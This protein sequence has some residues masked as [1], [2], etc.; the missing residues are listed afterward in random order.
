M[1]SKTEIKAAP[2]EVTSHKIPGLS[3]VELPENVLELIVNYVSESRSDLFSFL[4]TCK[5]LRVITENASLQLSVK[6]K[7]AQKDEPETGVELINFMRLSTQWKIWRLTID[8]DHALFDSEK[9][10]SAISVESEFLKKFSRL[11]IFSGIQHRENMNRVRMS[12]LNEIIKIMC[13]PSTKISFENLDFEYFPLTGLETLEQVKRVNY[14]GL[15]NQ[16]G[17]IAYNICPYLEGLSIRI[18][19]FAVSPFGCR[20]PRMVRLT[21]Q[22]FLEELNFIGSWDIYSCSF[23]AQKEII[24]EVLLPELKIFRI[25][26]SRLDEI[27]W[28]VFL[29]RHALK[30]RFLVINGCSRIPEERIHWEIL[31]ESCR[32]LQ[33]SYEILDG[34]CLS[35]FLSE[36]FLSDIPTFAKSWTDFDY[37]IERIDYIIKLLAKFPNIKLLMVSLSGCSLAQLHAE[38]IL[39]LVYNLCHLDVFIV[40]SNIP[41]HKLPFITS[42]KNA[43]EKYEKCKVFYVIDDFVKLDINLEP[44][45]YSR[46][47]KLTKDFSWSLNDVSNHEDY[48]QLSYIL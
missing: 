43:P 25:E 2:K 31:P 1:S 21:K 42:I 20:G 38:A 8:F 26:G 22:N 13:S 19:H 16:G 10:K 15:I 14:I 11:I 5:R 6:I 39:K 27:K 30:L 28:P 35:S 17:H 33:V 29:K 41:R 23:P 47:M 40:K 24:S 36:L 32:T 4:W 46:I 44:K 45:L 34:C 9:F 7:P 48:D 18:Q 12:Y 37:I 3:L